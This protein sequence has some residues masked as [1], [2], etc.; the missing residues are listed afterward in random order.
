MR[1]HRLSEDFVC[2]EGTRAR[3]REV[4]ELLRAAG[5][6]ERRLDPWTLTFNLVYHPH[7]KRNLPSVGH[8]SLIYLKLK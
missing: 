8:T 5:V 2:F 3:I 1:A 6:P 7:M 4:R